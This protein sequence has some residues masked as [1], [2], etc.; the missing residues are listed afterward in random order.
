MG[1]VWLAEHDV[2][3]RRAA[4]KIMHASYAERPEVVARFFNEAK[5]TTSIADPG[6]VQVFDFG[7]HGGRPYIVMELLEGETLEQRVRRTGM[8]AVADS[9]RIVRQVASALGAAHAR[10]IV[11]RDIKPDNIFIVR[12]SE[13]PG[14]ER[15]KIVDFGIAK[16]SDGPT[17]GITTTSAV[18]GTPVYMSP[19][20]CRGGGHVDQRSDIY[21]LGCVMYTLLTGRPP[22]TGIGPGDLISMHIREPAERPSKRASGIPKAVDDLV[23]RCL[24]KDP[25]KRFS[26]GTD[27]A[28]AVDALMQTPAVT[29]ARARPNVEPVAAAAA[30]TLSSAS[31][32]SYA[33]STGRIR[34]RVVIGSLLAVAVVAVGVV[35]LT[36]FGDGAESIVLPPALVLPSVAPPP[37][38]PVV[39]PPP[40]APP[41]VETPAAVAP[42]PVAPPVVKPVV[43]PKRVKPIDPLERRR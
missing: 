3:G 11:H 6:I 4:L 1:E 34:R 18:L 2:L 13:V 19:E 8:P 43:R 40:P 12:D 36:R 28:H 41:P 30:T 5:A 17:A 42:P 38:P 10:N 7:E 23:M 27:L 29:S 16:L 33:T 20:Q 24:E 37:P 14:G 15:A 26:T 39:T 31:G 21:S 9:L 22:F 32:I 35:A 25:A